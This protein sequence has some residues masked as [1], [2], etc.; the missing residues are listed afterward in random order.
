M[1]QMSQA[2]A[3]TLPEGRNDT[4]SVSFSAVVRT[5][6]ESPFIHL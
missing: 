3:E 5:M 4:R 1:L 6:A 2:V